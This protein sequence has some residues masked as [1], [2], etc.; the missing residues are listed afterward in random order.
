VKVGGEGG[1][2]GGEDANSQRGMNVGNMYVLVEEEEGI[3]SLW[4][5]GHQIKCEWEEG[6]ETEG[7]EGGD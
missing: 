4:G 5:N 3:T 1:G 2:G 6:R 7:T